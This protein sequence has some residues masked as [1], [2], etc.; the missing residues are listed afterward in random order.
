[1]KALV[2][3]GLGAEN[4][5]LMEIPEPKLKENEIKI[6]VH[7]AG[8]CGTDLHIIADEYP[9]NYPVAMGHEFSG[10]VEELGSA[11]KDFSIGDRVVSLT[12]VETCGKC[13]YC[14]EGL[15]ML[16]ENRKSIGSGV[17]GAFAE[18][19]KVP[20]HLAFKIPETVSMDEA[21][22]SEPLACMVRCVIERGTVK[23]GDDVLISGPG[24]IGLLTMQLANVSGGRCIVLGTSNDL[25]RLR[26]AKELGA[27]EIIVVDQENAFDRIKELTNSKGVDVAFE[28]AGAEVSA[29]NCLKLLKKT[30]LYVQVGLFASSINFDMNLALTKEINLTNGYASERTSWVRTLKLLEEG[31]VK[32]APLI[33]TILPIEKWAEGVD[34]SKNKLAFKV[35]L[36][37]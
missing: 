15:L 31:K 14:Y 16:C 21:V 9:A 25:E 13:S 29:Q 4:V 19:L 34:L 8:I 28:C 1:M 20:E 24:T 11:V 7:A 10:T 17:N 26:L 18:Y 35:L 12:A 5:L 30:G 36:K 6:K 22:L 3:K 2:K 27:A 33:S 37:P 23:A 32:V